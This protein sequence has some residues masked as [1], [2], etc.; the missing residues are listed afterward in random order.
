[1]PTPDEALLMDR[2]EEPEA[3]PPFEQIRELA[4]MWALRAHGVM[5]EAVRLR[6]LPHP[7]VDDPTPATTGRVLGGY[8]EQYA[9]LAR[10]L[11]AVAELFSDPMTTIEV[12]NPY[13]PGEVPDMVE[14]VRRDS[15]AL[16]R[17]DRAEVGKET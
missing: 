6:L 2:P 9:G 5:E 10:S 11:A 16:M 4:A 14:Q 12:A 1:M 17:K 7:T 15:E 3:P 8:A 13:A